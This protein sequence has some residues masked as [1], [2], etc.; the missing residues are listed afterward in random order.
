MAVE[1]ALAAQGQT[2]QL[3]MQFRRSGTL[4]DPV[5][6]RQVLILDQAGA[7]V[8]T[9]PQGSII[10]DSTGMYHVDWAVS[11]TQAVALY[12]DRW[13]ATSTTGATEKQFT[14]T[15]YVLPALAGP[16]VGVGRYLT[17]IEVRAYLPPETT[18]SDAQLAVLVALAQA[19]AEKITGQY[20][21]PITEARV[22]DGSGMAVQDIQDPIIS[23]SGV[24][25]RCDSSFET[26][27]IED[28]R[29]SGSGTMLAIGNV[30]PGPFSRS[31]LSRLSANGCGWPA[32]FQNVEITGAWGLYATAPLLIKAA[33]GLLVK[34]AAAC[35]NPAGVPYNA[36]DSENA[37][38]DYSYTLRKIFEGAKTHA[39]TGYSDVDAI[40]AG[41]PR[42]PRVAVM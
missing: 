13:F 37:G 19:T 26:Q 35:D 16:G 3:R 27:A 31:S 7:T 38:T 39:E 22:F 40:L 20:F 12:N 9:F 23:V 1:R 30:I 29:I 8:E 41:Y 17:P 6:V 15:F 14:L 28:I 4:F 10:R 24:R 21:T 34:Y 36:I 18:L 5:Q 32:G 2:V 25:F 42:L 11:A 33:V